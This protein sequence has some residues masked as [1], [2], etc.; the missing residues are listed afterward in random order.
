MQSCIRKRPSFYNSHIGTNIKKVVLETSS[1]YSNLCPVYKV[2]IDVDT[3]NFTYFGKMN[4]PYRRYG[5][6]KGLVTSFNI[7]LLVE[8]IESIGF[9]SHYVSEYRSG[10]LDISTNKYTV[11]LRDGTHKT[12]VHDAQAGSAQLFALKLMIDN[13]ITTCRWIT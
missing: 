6:H 5:F 3:G 2:V 9:F 7:N 12:V 4:V 1:C 8:F 11:I 10:A 13:A